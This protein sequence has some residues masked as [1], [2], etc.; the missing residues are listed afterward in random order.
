MSEPK[1]KIPASEKKLLLSFISNLKEKQSLAQLQKMHD[2]GCDNSELLALCME[3]VKNVGLSFEKGEFY[4]SALIMAGEIMRQAAEFLTTSLPPAADDSNVLGH[5]LLGTIKDDIHDLGKNIFKDMLKCNGFKVTDL[6]VDVPIQVFMEKTR[7]LEPDFVAIS[8]L[9]TNCLDNLTEAVKS[10]RGV[11]TSNKHHII[12]GGYCIDQLVN[13]QVKADIWFSDAK[14]A[15]EY[16][17]EVLLLKQKYQ[18][19]AS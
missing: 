13:E 3:G 17:K 8:C 12:V 15:V 10:L 7:E 18:P 11:T 16:C 2:M 4:I 14:L 6:G 19:V 1:K 5:V 9:L